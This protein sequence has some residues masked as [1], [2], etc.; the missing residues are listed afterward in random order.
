MYCATTTGH[1]TNRVHVACACHC[2]TERKKRPK[3]AECYKKMAKPAKTMCMYMCMHI[4]ASSQS[5][6]YVCP[7][8]RNVNTTR[9][10]ELIAHRCVHVH[11]LD[12]IV[13]LHEFFHGIPNKTFS[14]QLST[15][16]R[17]GGTEG[18]EGRHSNTS[19]N[20]KQI[21]NSGQTP[22]STSN[23]ENTC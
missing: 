15:G 7:A 5:H 2:Q 1:N 16:E 12:A 13:L 20:I 14:N 9:A 18:T 6:A 4:Q 3:K 8:K 17:R 21:H 23:T 11:V 22:T 19:T 10:L